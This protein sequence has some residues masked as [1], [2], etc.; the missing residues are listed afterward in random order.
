MKQGQLLHIAELGTFAAGELTTE[1]DPEKPC[2]VVFEAVGAT[3]L[4]PFSL[5]L[6]V[7]SLLADENPLEGEQTWP[8]KAELAGDFGDGDAAAAAGDDDDDDDDDDDEDDED[9]EGDD[10]EDVDAERDESEKGGEGAGA[11]SAASMLALRST[12]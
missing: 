1:R 4:C 2:A 9:D 10:D 6:P 3:G 5:A 7:P 8:T 11:R 12:P